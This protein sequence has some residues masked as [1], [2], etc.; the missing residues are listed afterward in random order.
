MQY[1]LSNELSGTKDRK[2]STAN[3]KSPKLYMIQSH[4]HSLPSS[5]T[6]TSF[7]FLCYLLPYLP[8]GSCPTHKSVNIARLPRPTCR[9]AYRNLIQF[10]FTII[11]SLC[12]PLSYSLCNMLKF[13]S[14]LILGFKHFPP[15]FRFKA[16]STI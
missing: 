13:L 12:K 10:V 3:I 4:F 1:K 7:T 16:P 6:M 11:S 2:F 14:Y 9:P 5:P 15:L 8:F